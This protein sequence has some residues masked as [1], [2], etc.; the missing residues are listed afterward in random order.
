MIDKV[1][2]DFLVF[3]LLKDEWKEF[4]KEAE[5]PAFWAH[6]RFFFTTKR[7]RVFTKITKNGSPLACISLCS[8]CLPLCSLWINVF[9]LFQ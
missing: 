4:E 7:N 6:L 2:Q 8:P 3:G 5:Y 1:K 9:R